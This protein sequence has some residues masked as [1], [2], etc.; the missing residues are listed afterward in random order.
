MDIR[1]TENAVHHIRKMLESHADSIGLRLGTRKSGCSGYAYTVNYADS[2]GKDDRVFEAE[3]IKVIVDTGSLPHL[4]GMTIDYT[5][6]GLL[7]EG[8]EFINPNVESSC[9]CGDSIAFRRLS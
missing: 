3:G 5:K 7:H 9:G 2:I 8:L 6:D 1:L 4:N